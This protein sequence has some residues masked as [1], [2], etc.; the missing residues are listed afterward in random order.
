[1]SLATLILRVS[2]LGAL[3]FAANVLKCLR[4]SMLIR[5]WTIPAPRP[6]DQTQRR[7]RYERDLAGNPLRGVARNLFRAS[8]VLP[9]C[10]Q[11]SAREDAVGQS[12]MARDFLRECSRAHD[13]TGS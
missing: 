11:V 12:F 2:P 1:M 4:P 3:F 9:S 6:C 8:F 5:E 10:R 7:K 13:F